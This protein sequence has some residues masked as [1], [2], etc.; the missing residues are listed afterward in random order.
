MSI[1]MKRIKERFISTM[2]QVADVLNVCPTELKRDDYIRI[3]VDTDI[4]GR[5]NK[6]ELNLIGG[7]KE[8]KRLYVE[9]N[10]KAPAEKPRVLFLD[11]ETSPILGYV[12][13]LWNNNVGLNQIETDWHLLSWSAKWLGEDEVIYQDQRDAKNIEDDSKLLK[14]IWELLDQASIIVTQN[15][16]AFDEKKLNARFI[17]NG[18]EPPSSY[19]HIDTKQIAKRKFGFTS[20]RL[21]YMTSKLCTKYEKSKHSKFSGFEL[22]KECLAGNIEAWDSMKDYNKLDV[23]SLE[24]LYTKLIPWDNSV[25]FNVYHSNLMNEC[26]CGSTDFKKAGY[27]FT[28][29]GKYQRYKCKS[30]GKEYRDGDNLLS[31]NKRK[32][33]LKRTV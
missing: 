29:S 10:G 18:F 9:P 4:Q 30:C 13:S 7:F 5:L 17:M 3:A 25:N 2:N 21:E 15:G 31:K 24:E 33:L 11:I 23:L 19:Q 20:N 1:K 32:S 12:W 6:E 26:T 14:G 16:K 22:W 28:N 27:H 8:A